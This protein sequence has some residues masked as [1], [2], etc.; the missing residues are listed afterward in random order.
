MKH[1]EKIKTK[2][3][4]IKKQAKKKQRQRIEEEKL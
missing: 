2:E 4:K 1:A 3:A